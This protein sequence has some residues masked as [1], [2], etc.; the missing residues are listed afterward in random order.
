MYVTLKSIQKITVIL[1][2]FFMGGC[3]SNQKESSQDRLT[4]G[5]VQKEIRVGMTSSEVISVLGSPNVVS[6]DDQ[7]QEVWVYDR[8]ST[9][10]SQKGAFG[11][12]ILFG[13]TSSEA[14]SSQQ[15]FTVII[16]FDKDGRVRDLSYHSSK[17]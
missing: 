10:V 12:L 5:K 13:M 11:G 16:K 3:V 17:F 9:K 7:R 14:S 8:I 4:L 2:I 15:S 6:L 1:L